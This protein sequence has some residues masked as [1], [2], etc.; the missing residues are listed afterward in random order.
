[1]NLVKDHLAYLYGTTSD[2]F[3][4]K[5]KHMNWLLEYMDHLRKKGVAMWTIS[6]AVKP[7]RSFYKL[8]G[9]TL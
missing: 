7:V 5:F 9:A 3:E 6:H 1:M 8:S 2:D 4:S